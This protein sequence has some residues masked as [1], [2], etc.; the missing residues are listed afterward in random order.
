[1]LAE[2]APWCTLTLSKF[3]FVEA[4][5]PSAVFVPA[6]FTIQY[7]SIEVPAVKD[8]FGFTLTAVPVVFI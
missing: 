6:V 3:A 8:P 4:G 2:Y 7:S 5:V 1:M